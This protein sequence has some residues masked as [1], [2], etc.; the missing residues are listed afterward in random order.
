LKFFEC[1]SRQPITSLL[2]TAMIGHVAK[3]G[4]KELL[5]KLNNVFNQKDNLGQL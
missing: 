4:N 5:S 3:D 2:S 1:R